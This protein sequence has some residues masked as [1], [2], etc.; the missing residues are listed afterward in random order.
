M[1]VRDTH[2]NALNELERLIE[3]LELG[4]Q[5]HTDAYRLINRCEESFTELECIVEAV[6]DAIEEV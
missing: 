3:R 5:D 6:R 1:K 2:D 4:R